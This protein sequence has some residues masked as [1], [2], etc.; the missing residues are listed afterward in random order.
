MQREN[1]IMSDIAQTLALARSKSAELPRDVTSVRSW[2]YRSTLV[3]KRTYARDEKSQTQELRWLWI[4]VL[5]Y[6]STIFKS[7]RALL[8]NWRRALRTANEEE[9][10]VVA[11]CLS[12]LLCA[13]RRPT[14]CSTF[15]HYSMLSSAFDA[16]R[17]LLLW[18]K[19]KKNPKS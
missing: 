8:Y 4:D 15:T 17:I 12:V 19:N 11:A 16:F 9:V 3:I 13:F 18:V 6:N 2:K 1:L 14:L 5:S 7:L 10:R